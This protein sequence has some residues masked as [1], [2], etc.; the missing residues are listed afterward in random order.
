M[1]F[2]AGIV[3]A[4]ATS[5]GFTKATLWLPLS[6]ALEDAQL[7]DINGDG[8]ADLCGHTSEGLA[9]ALAP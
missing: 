7:G 9:C 8:R 5:H 3:C 6:A 2:L 1:R 4:L